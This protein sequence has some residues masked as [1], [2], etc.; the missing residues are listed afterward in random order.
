M[1]DRMVVTITV[2]SWALEIPAVAALLQDDPPEDMIPNPDGTTDLF[3]SEAPWGE[4]PALES[5]LITAGIAFDRHSDGKYEYD[6]ETRFFRPAA[7]DVP[8]CDATV[9]T[10][11]NGEPVVALATFKTLAQAGPLTVD[12]ITQALGIPALSVAAW[13]QAHAPIPIHP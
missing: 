12:A 13:G 3:Q 8:V 6:P 2:P 7:A 1:S 5:L 10:L 9:L 4:W 11:A